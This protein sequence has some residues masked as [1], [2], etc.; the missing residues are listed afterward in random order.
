LEA[1][2]IGGAVSAEDFDSR[3]GYVGLEASNVNLLSTSG[4]HSAT[5]PFR[6]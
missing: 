4:L 5:T 3:G 2:A 1:N 6:L